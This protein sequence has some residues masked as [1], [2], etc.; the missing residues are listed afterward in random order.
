LCFI[1]APGTH[2]AYIRKRKW[3][4]GSGAGGN[5][6][7]KENFTFATAKSAKIPADVES[8]CKTPE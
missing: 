7:K 1:K 4:R 6:A 8:G 3:A 2:D 5:G